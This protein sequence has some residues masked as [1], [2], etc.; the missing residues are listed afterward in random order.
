VQKGLVA[1]W[2]VALAAALSGGTTAAQ[3]LDAAAYPVRP[4]RLVV[5]YSAGGGNDILARLLAGPMS[6]DLHQPVLVDN[7]P[8][9]QSIV[10][11]ELVAKSAP[12][13]Y[14]LLIAPTGPMTINPAIYSRLP[15]SPLRDFAPVSIVGDFPLI[16]AVSTALPVNSVRELIEYAKSHP[17]GVNYASSAAPFQVAAELFNQR[18]G[19]RFAHIPYKGSGDSVNAVISG[20]VTMTISDSL[21]IAGQLK[22]GKL[23]GLAVTAAQ[24]SPH[25]PDIPTMA[26]AGL[27]DMVIK[28]FSGVVAPAGT[29]A[30]VI[31][32]LNEA[33]VRTVALPE[34]QERFTALGMEPVTSS[35][36]EFTRV[37]AQGIERWTAVA[38]AANIKAD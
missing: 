29:P 21:P 32:R 8:G 18:T 36:E 35:P 6:E 1:A 30:S 38:K 31:R 37:I 10:A 33:I 16:L 23:R 34:M 25:F 11:C 14:T 7:R 22:G 3:P 28:L 20:E 15:Y 2:L 13:G 17:A 27:N 24:R 9:A 19:T 26:E 4:I 12:D 5:G